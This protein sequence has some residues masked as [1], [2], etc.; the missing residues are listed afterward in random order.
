LNIA[1]K[2]ISGLFLVFALTG[3]VF[4][5]QYS[6]G[7]FG[8][9]LGANVAFGT[10]IN[11]VGLNLHLYF[12]KDFFQTTSAVRMYYNISNLGPKLRYPELVLSQ[13]ICFGYGAQKA[14][15]NPFISSI[16]NQTGF[17]NAVSY[18]Y[19]AY[20]NHVR[21]TQQTGIVSFLVKGFS[22]SAENDIL[23]RPTLDRFRTGAFLLQY[24]YLDIIQA[25][26]NCTIWTG[27]FGRKKEIF[28]IKAF[29]NNCYMD[30]TGG[31]HTNVANGLLSAQVKYNAGYGQ[32]IQANLGV[33]AEQVRNAIQNKLIHNMRFVPG[34]IKKT[35]NCHL[36]MLDDKGG[37]FLYNEGQN[38]RRPRLYLNI[39]SNANVFY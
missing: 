28:L 34:A 16:S 30:T 26:I 21:T 37:L 29:Y 27:Q 33:D 1:K 38:I 39:F 19:N 8:F 17:E 11:R 32:N 31:V 5:Q 4:S 12:V 7:S 14:E 10:H 23:A 36:P 18:S 2:I 24:Q 15:W 3:Q 25:G 20:F 22:L 35:R 9:N 13:G 6:S